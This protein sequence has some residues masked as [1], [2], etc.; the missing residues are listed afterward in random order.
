MIEDKKRIKGKEVTDIADLYDENYFSGYTPENKNLKRLF[1]NHLDWVKGF[2]SSGRLLDVGCATGIW[3]EVAQ[4]GGFEAYGIDIS[5]VAIERCKTIFAHKVVCANVEDELPY[6]DNF[7]DVCTMFEVLEHLKSPSTFGGKI[8][9]VLKDEGLCFIVTTNYNS[10]SRRIYGKR[11]YGF[12]PGYHLTPTITPEELKDAL[13]KENFKI[14]ELYTRM[15]HPLMFPS[16]GDLPKPIQTIGM[17]FYITIS[18]LDRIILHKFRFERFMN[19][20]DYLF[21]VAKKLK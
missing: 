3:L 14:V 12:A 18:I 6:E 8:R 9:K 19:I 17:G 4:N 15:Y 20:G 7:F 1:S 10:I 11:W 21:C 2:V 5:K 16:I 13:E